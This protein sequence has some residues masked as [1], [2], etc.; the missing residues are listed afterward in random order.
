MIADPSS[1]ESGTILVVYQPSTA[2]KIF[3]DDSD[4]RFES[5]N[6]FYKS[7]LYSVKIQYPFES[8]YH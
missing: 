2:K 3:I 8:L 1:A 5:A 4:T 7:Y 6:K